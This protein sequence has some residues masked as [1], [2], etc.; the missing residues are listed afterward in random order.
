M[1]PLLRMLS[2]MTNDPLQQTIQCPPTMTLALQFREMMYTRNS[3]P[4]QLMFTCK[5]MDPLLRMLSQMTTEMHTLQQTIHQCPSTMILAFQFRDMMYTRNNVHPQLMF[6]CQFMDPLLRMLSQMTTE[7]HT[8]QQTIHQ[9]PPTMILALHFREM[10]YTRN[11]LH[12]QLIV[13]CKKFNMRESWKRKIRT[14]D[15]F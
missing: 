10:M 15:F 13:T 11:S 1:S 2:Q 12:P 9:C 3:L 14:R 4:P 5:F 8:L 7:M 6:T